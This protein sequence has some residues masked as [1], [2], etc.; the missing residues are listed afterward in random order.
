M[1]HASDG[2][3]RLSHVP[4]GPFLRGGTSYEDETPVS[5]VYLSDF[6]IGTY[7]VTNLEYR[8]FVAS[9]GHR[10]S[11]FAADSVF[12][13]DHSPVVGVSWFDATEFCKWASLETGSKVRLPTEAEFEKASRGVDGRT[14]PWGEAPLTSDRANV[15][16][17][18][19][20]TNR[21]DHYLNESP[22][23]VRDT[24]GNVWEWCED[25]YSPTAYADASS[26]VGTLRVTRGGSWRSETFRAT[27]AHRCFANPSL[28]SDRQ[29]FRVVVVGGDS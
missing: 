1:T 17:F 26:A 20:H 23:G 7:P 6:A 12:G 24:L 13:R 25:W 27:C 14:F 22:Y 11:P 21:V 29:G 8:T 4:A 5:S 2:G 18:I 28:R 15:A 16:S 3:I 9:T 19:G 10:P